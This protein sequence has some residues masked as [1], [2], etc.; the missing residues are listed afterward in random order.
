ML[1]AED[2]KEK[3]QKKAIAIKFELEVGIGEILDIEWSLSGSY[4]TPVAIMTPMELAG[5]VVERANLCNLN[6]IQK[7]GIKIGDK[8]KVMRRG[9]VIPRVM[10][11]A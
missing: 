1:D 9:E 6:N 3:I 11:K 8:V 5:V 10:S 7:L 4:L 2:Q